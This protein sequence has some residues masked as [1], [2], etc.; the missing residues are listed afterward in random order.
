MMADALSIKPILVMRNSDIILAERPRKRSTAI[1]TIVNMLS[2][3]LDRELIPSIIG[4]SNF[5]CEADAQLMRQEIEK[6]FPKYLIIEGNADPMIAANTGP[7]LLL[8]ACFAAA[9]KQ[10]GGRKINF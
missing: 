6:E 8:V 2:E 9:N 5:L 10:I 7:G 1:H 4:I 3:T